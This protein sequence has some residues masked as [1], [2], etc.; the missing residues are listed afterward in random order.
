MGLTDHLWGKHCQRDFKDCK[1]QEYESWK[2]MYIRVSEER[3]RKLQKLTKSIVSA[4]SKKSKG[5]YST[6]KTSVLLFSLT[7]W[8]HVA[9]G[10]VKLHTCYYFYLLEKNV[11]LF[12]IGRQVKMAFIHT[13][14]KPPRDVRIQQEIHGTAVQQP[15]Q[16]KCRW[17]TTSYAYTALNLTIFV[18]F[19][20]YLLCMFCIISVI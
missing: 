5:V 3:E 9:L 13:V 19:A 6:L 11:I 8:K 1:L 4:H 2:E 10:M 20:T 14:A 7:L 12:F 17:T 15:H 18:L 16:L